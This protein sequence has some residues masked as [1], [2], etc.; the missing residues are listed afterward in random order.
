[1]SDLLPTLTN[2]AALSIASGDTSTNPVLVYLS[3]GF[4]RGA[5]SESLEKIARMV[6]RISLGVRCGMNILGLLTPSCY[7]VA[8]KS[9]TFFC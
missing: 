6:S 1:M 4:L 7:L 5:L 8:I 9:H 3:L 2:P